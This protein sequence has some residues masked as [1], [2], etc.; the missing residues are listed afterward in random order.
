MNYASPKAGLHHE[1]G[2]PGAASDERITTMISNILGPIGTGSLNFNTG[3]AAV[4]GATDI[5]GNLLQQV[6][7]FFRDAFGS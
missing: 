7:I 4:D 3:S 6:G 2:A 1:S 5:F